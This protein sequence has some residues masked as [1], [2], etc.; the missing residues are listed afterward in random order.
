LYPVTL[1]DGGKSVMLKTLF[2]NVCVNDCAYCPFRA[3]QDVRRCTMDV[4]GLVRVFLD[5][6]RAGTVFGL[7]LS[8][9][10]VGT[11]DATMERLTAVAS[12][13]RRREKFKGYI[14]LKI[15]PGASDAAIEGAVSL[16]STVSVNI[17]VPGRKHFEQLSRRKSYLDDIIRPMKRV[18]ALTA[19]GER[20]HR[21]GQVTQFLVGAS[22]ETDREI[23]NY[24]WGLYRRLGLR[25]VYFSAY[26]RGLGE[27]HIP[28]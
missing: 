24:S 10:V 9:G 28:G 4:D 13:L 16:A 21:T 22:D 6:Y 15:I 17:E 2:S 3:G 14:H 25:R 23:V 8:S 5:Y 19:K 12:V 18:S 1:A 20:H 27:S 26:Q 11:P 7:F